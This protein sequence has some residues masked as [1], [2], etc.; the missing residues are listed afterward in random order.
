MF[1]RILLNSLDEWSKKHNRKPLIIRGARQVGK[2]TLINYI[3]KDIPL[4][5]LTINADEKKYTDILASR[6]FKKM[7]MS[8]SSLE[9]HKR[10]DMELP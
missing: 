9:L 3:L 6:D 4:K 1:N 5:K 7:K 10:A 2:T 8:D